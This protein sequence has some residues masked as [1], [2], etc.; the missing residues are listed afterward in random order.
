MSVYTLPDLPYDYAAL[1]PHISGKIME[2]HHDK[3]HAAYVAGANTA[4]DKLAELREA[5]ALAPVVNL[6]EKNLA[7]HLGGHTNHSVFW[8][9]LSPEGGDKPEG[10][11]A[12]AIDDQFGSFDAFRSHFS[13]NANAIQ[14]SGWSILAWDSIGQRLIIVQLYD[15]QGNISI[16]L[17]PLLMLDMWEHAFYLDY[18]NVKGDYVN[19]FWNIVNWTDVADR[20]TKARTQTTGLI[21][22]A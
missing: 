4:L 5:D 6:H 11:L 14:G 21:V 8:N 7:F 15:Q 2:L 3:H 22:P 18:Q 13:A 17:T 9:N 12:A 19:A 20:F 10:E 16:G 1:E